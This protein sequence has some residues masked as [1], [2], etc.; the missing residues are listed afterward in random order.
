MTPLNLAR[1]RDSAQVTCYW[2]QFALTIPVLIILVLPAV[3]GW[4]TSSPKPST[5]G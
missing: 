1:L 3:S 4:Y 5:P 2:L